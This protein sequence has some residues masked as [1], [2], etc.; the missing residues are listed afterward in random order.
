M[1]PFLLLIVEEGDVG[2][3]SYAAGLLSARGL[4]LRLEYRDDEQYFGRDRTALLLIG[5]RRF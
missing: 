1:H 3:R 2:R 5:E 4:G